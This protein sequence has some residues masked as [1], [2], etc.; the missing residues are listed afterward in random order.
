MSKDSCSFVSNIFILIVNIF[1]KNAQIERR[2]RKIEA[3]TKVNVAGSLMR[4]I[5]YSEEIIQEKPKKNVGFRWDAE[6]KRW[7]ICVKKK[8]QERYGEDENIGRIPK[9]ASSSSSQETMN[10][11]K[12]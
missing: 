8:R 5:Y 10:F 11:G 1:A 3:H 4:R 2:S 6:E 12:S 7:F 9:T